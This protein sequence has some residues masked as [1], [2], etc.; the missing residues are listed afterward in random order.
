MCPAPR[1]GPAGVSQP[2][3]IA[4]QAFIFVEVDLENR[5][6]GAAKYNVSRD[7]CPCYS[8]VLRSIQVMSEPA[9]C[10]RA[11]KCYGWYTTVCTY[12]ISDTATEG[13]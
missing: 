13:T 1:N 6:Y 5:H 2:A 7:G 11:L 4:V 8:Y 9:R 10:A 12:V 3:V